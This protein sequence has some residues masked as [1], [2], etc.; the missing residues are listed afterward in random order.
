[1]TEEAIA[2]AA[3]LP[4]FDN[5]VE[6][7]PLSGGIT[8][9]NLTVRDGD[10]RFVVR[11]GSDIPEHG[12]F[13]WN[14]LALSRAAQAAGVSPAV[15]YHEPGV[16]V[17]D[18]IDAQTYTEDMASDPANVPRI[19][20]LLKQTHQALGPQLTGPVLTFW[21]FQVNRTYAARLRADGSRYVAQLPDLMADLQRL[22]DATGPVT[23]VIGHNDLLAA[24][25][26]DDGVRLW[27][28][29]WEY[30][31]FNTPLFDLAGLA[32]NNGF[33]E[34]QER[35]MLEQYFDRP[36]D[37]HWRAYQAMKCVSLMR[38]TLWS[39]TSEIHSDLDFDYAA[40][41]A[42]NMARFQAA[43]QDFQST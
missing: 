1:M 10:R 8:N 25:I 32:G 23:L 29:D 3:R 27:L 35:D 24:N 40:Y 14:E 6:I 16:L 9:V 34:S 20:A 17:L 42:E 28:I 13:R 33:S 11:L 4:C 30:G 41:T 19:I 18:F 43:L 21:P 38:E 22:E 26:L 2:R 31:G 37:T 7:A 12:V 15:H 39:M 5:P 36:A